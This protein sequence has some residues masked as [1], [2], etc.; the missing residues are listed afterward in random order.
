VSPRVEANETP[1]R[2]AIGDPAVY[3]TQTEIT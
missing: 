2:E 1:E 3:G